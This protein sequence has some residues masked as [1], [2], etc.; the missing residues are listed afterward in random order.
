MC[1]FDLLGID[2]SE[3]RAKYP[4]LHIRGV[5]LNCRV[6]PTLRSQG[7]IVDGSYDHSGQNRRNL[8][9]QLSQQ[10]PRGLR[11]HHLGSRSPGCRKI[12]QQIFWA[13]HRPGCPHAKPYSTRSPE[14]EGQSCWCQFPPVTALV[15][16]AVAQISRVPDQNQ[17]K[18]QL[19]LVMT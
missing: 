18:Q 11:L 9:T 10:F 5:T 16:Q 6:K 13:A 2:R 3:P 7:S 4:T 14:Q 17:R 19:S 15:W 1:G 8:K 12:A